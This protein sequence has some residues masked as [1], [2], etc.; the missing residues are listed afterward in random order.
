M[1]GVSDTG[2]IPKTYLEILNDNT[3]LANTPEFFGIEFPTTPDSVFGN[4]NGVF[5]GSLT[6]L[7]NLAQA[8]AAQQNVDTASGIY[9]DYLGALVGVNRNLSTGSSGTL[10]FYTV[11]SYTIPQGTQASDFNNN[12]VSTNTAQDSTS[13]A[14]HGLTL[15]VAT[16]TPFA[17]YSITVNGTAASYFAGASPTEEDIILGLD[18]AVTNLL[19]GVTSTP[20]EI[21]TVLSLLSDSDTNNLNIS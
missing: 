15:Q 10:L 11:D 12:T 18:T 2:F 19:T 13:T 1:A 21:D 8:V 9:L 17:L 14:A 6:D 3:S 7:W 16:V 20:I 5:S 4:L